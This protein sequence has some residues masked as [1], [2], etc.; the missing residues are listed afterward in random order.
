MQ[1]LNRTHVIKRCADSSE[2]RP[3]EFYDP[4]I[5]GGKRCRP[6]RAAAIFAFIAFAFN[7]TACGGPE[8]AYLIGATLAN[9]IHTDRVP[10]DYVAEYASGQECNLL[11]SIEDGGPL[12]RKSFTRTVIEPPLYCYR[13]LGEPSCYVSP[14]PYKTGAQT[15]R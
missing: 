12:C 6:A 9:F 15:I 5:K 11:K 2:I 7:L 4:G 13:T 10:I 1:D 8:S 3:S 14:D